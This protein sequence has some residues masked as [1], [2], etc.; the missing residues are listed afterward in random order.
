MYNKNPKKPARSPLHELT[1]AIKSG[2]VDLKKQLSKEFV[3]RQERCRSVRR[4]RALYDFIKES[5]AYS[6]RVRMYEG[7]GKHA[8]FHWMDFGEREP[9]E[10]FAVST[11]GSVVRHTCE[12]SGHNGDSYGDEFELLDGE[13]AQNVLNAIAGKLEGIALAAEERRLEEAEHR[14]KAIAAKRN[15]NARLKSKGVL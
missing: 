3:D 11:D 13:R 1:A 6:H 12:Y 15:L 2:K 8:G 10:S 14:R 5:D 4:I 7:S 9:P